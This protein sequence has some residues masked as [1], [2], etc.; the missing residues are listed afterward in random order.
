MLDCLC[1]EL[2]MHSVPGDPQSTGMILPRTELVETLYFGGGTPSILTVGEI[3]RLTREVTDHYLLAPNAEI[4][5]EA[6]PDDIT[7]EKL[8]DWKKAAVNRLSVGIQSFDDETLTWMNRAHD[9]SQALRSMTWIKEAG[10]S[11]YSVDLIFG[12]PHLTDEK[13]ITNIERVIEAKVP[14]IACYALTVE[15]R[16]ALS[17]MIR[18]GKKE[19]INQEDQA[20]QFEILM[21]KMRGAGYEHYE[22]SN[23][24]LPGYR[25]RHNSS[26]WQ[27]KKYL[28]IGPSAH[29]FDGDN[30]Y[31]NLA[32]NPL[33]IKALNEGGVFFE[34][35][36]LT[37]AQKFDEYIMTGLRTLEGVSLAFIRSHFGNALYEKT[38]RRLD[39]VQSDW[40][41]RVGENVYLTD[42]GKLFTDR[43]SVALFE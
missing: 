9:A 22:T 38:I 35:E 16:T 1:K 20:R 28:G 26:Y 21:S 4:T 25:S 23:F 42:K 27:Q 29:S 14:H 11:N 36:H 34:H 33:Y 10:F 24:A 13:W 18:L 39:A 7:P 32:N 31:W 30:R 43:V 37:P 19:D 40:I 5:L 6:N 12:I 15:S 8:A 17:K 3:R 41:G 2:R